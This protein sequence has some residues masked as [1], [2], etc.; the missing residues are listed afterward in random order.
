MTTSR[1]TFL[2]AVSLGAASIPFA[3]EFAH[4]AVARTPSVQDSSTVMF[5]AGGDPRSVIRDILEPFEEQIRAGVQGKRVVIKPNCVADAN[6]LC[7]THVESI[8]GVLDFLRPF[9]RG[10]VVVGESSASRAG[11]MK[12]FADYG[13]PAVEREYDVQLVDLNLEPTETRW[14]LGEN[15]Y[16]LEVEIIRTFLDPN[17]YVIS[18]ARMKTHNTVVCTLSMKNVLMASPV[19]TPPA[20]TTDAD[21]ETWNSSR[22]EKR[23]MHEGGSRGL[24]YN[25][26]LMAQHVW[27]NLAIVEG[28]VG[29]EGNGP[30][31]GTPVEHGVALAGLDPVAVDRVGVELMGVD[32]AN[33]G[34]LQW[35]SAAGLGQGNLDEITVVG[36][37]YR[38]HIRTY[39]MPDNI[40]RQLEWRAPLSGA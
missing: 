8:R 4:A 21:R 16:P 27:P 25:L 3:P 31:N 26:F 13:Y 36:G 40:D 38:P 20:S 12:A 23:K 18:L 30:S 15:R 11:T 6:Q 35:C 9:Y 32:P 34:Y 1:R 2:K 17:V 29:M 10:T 33:V 19:I 24:H 28:I 7:A 37:D 22:S 5:G 39:Q 14:I